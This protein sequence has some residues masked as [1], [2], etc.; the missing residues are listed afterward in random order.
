MG[1]GQQEMQVTE[2]HTSV[3]KSN[4]KP[5]CM[6]E[7]KDILIQ[8]GVTIRIWSQQD[9]VG[10]GTHRQGCNLAPGPD[11]QEHSPQKHQKEWRSEDQVP[12]CSHAKKT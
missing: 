7:L 8:V 4:S 11:S 1:A 6:L 3:L 2:I 9:R 10:W 12:M 5:A